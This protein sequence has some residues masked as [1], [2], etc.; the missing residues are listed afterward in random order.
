MQ[1]HGLVCEL[2]ERLGK[3]EGLGR[4]LVQCYQFAPSRSLHGGIEHGG[5]A[6]QWS[7]PCAEASNENEGCRTESALLRGASR[8]SINVP[9]IFAIGVR[10]DVYV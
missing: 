9:F 10:F 5:E 2:N 4:A 8:K 6:Y 1:Y 3:G 7:Q